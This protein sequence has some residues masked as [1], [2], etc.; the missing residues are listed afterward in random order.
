MC[1]LVIAGTRGAMTRT[2]LVDVLAMLGLVMALA[3]CSGDPPQGFGYQH[4]ADAPR[5]LPGH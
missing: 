3:G 4:P 5:D 2:A 1:K